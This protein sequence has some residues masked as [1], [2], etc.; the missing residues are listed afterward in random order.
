M[1]LRLRVTN[2]GLFVVLHLRVTD[3]H[4]LIERA[5]SPGSVDK[6]IHRMLSKRR[7][8]LHLLSFCPGPLR[9][10]PFIKFAAVEVNC[11][12]RPLGR[13]KKLYSGRSHPEQNLTN[14]YKYIRMYIHKYVVSVS[15]NAGKCE[16][17]G[18]RDIKILKKNRIGFGLNPEW[19]QISSRVLPERE[20]KV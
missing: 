16:F 1:V 3:F 7:L 5:F 4:L 6:R 17:I 18:N 10:S 15:R 13:C 8:S 11:L 2:F 20:E 9:K 12:T 14:V 19:L